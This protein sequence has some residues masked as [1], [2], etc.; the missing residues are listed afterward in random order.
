MCPHVPHLQTL[1]HILEDVVFQGNSA[2]GGLQGGSGDGGAL[3]L[4]GADAVLSGCHFVNNSCTRAA[5][6]QETFDAFGGAMV[7]NAFSATPPSVQV[8]PLPSPHCLLLSLR[9]RVHTE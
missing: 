9:V 5:H 2:G 7:A 4:E 1:L 6:S 3:V 8:L